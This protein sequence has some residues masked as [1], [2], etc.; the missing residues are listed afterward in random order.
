MTG[1]GES[2]GAGEELE[3]RISAERAWSGGRPG[4]PG[5][6]GG[7]HVYLRCRSGMPAAKPSLLA[8][9]S[10]FP[11]PSASVDGLINTGRLVD[12]Q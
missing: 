3:N 9:A 5:P 4:R 12:V 2:Q 10:A 11:G 8:G 6:V 7:R 1:A